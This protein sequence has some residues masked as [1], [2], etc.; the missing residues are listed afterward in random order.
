M[1]TK[2]M[3]K[4]ELSLGVSSS[5]H[6]DQ[7]NGKKDFPSFSVVKR[8]TIFWKVRSSKERMKDMYSKNVCVCV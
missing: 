2:D 5:I 3:G 1:R 4:C 7:W 6:Y 8:K